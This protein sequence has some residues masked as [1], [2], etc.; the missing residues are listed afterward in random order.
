MS[1]VSGVPEEHVASRIVRIYK[2]AKNVMQSGTN[3]I[4][5]WRMSFEARERWENPLMG[6]TSR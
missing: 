4:Q 3:N 5:H 1:L 2:P 6:W